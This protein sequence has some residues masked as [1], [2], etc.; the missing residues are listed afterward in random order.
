[1]AAPDFPTGFVQSLWSRAMHKIVFWRDNVAL[2]EMPWPH[3]LESGRTYARE[4]RRD[5]DATRSEVIDVA[6]RE[7][8]A[9]YQGKPAST[10]ERVSNRPW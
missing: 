3:G 5:Y 6:T 4:Y 1:M 10:P 2:V 9:T 8:I 7:V